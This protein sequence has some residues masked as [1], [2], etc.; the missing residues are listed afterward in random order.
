MINSNK[1]GVSPNKGIMN[2]DGKVEDEDEE[3]PPGVSDEEID[4][5]VTGNNKDEDSDS[6][7]E[8]EESIGITLPCRPDDKT[9]EEHNRTHF[10][11]RNWCE[12]CVRGRC[13][14]DPHRKSEEHDKNAVPIISIDYCYMN[15]EKGNKTKPIA[16]WHPSQSSD[17]PCSLTSF[18]NIL[19]LLCLVGLSTPTGN[20]GASLTS[21][22]F[23]IIIIFD[24]TSVVS[25]PG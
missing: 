21:L 9:V 15:E 3:L 24:F 18:L 8:A 23:L 7:G 19:N 5:E 14:E 12:V 20:S 4:N 10:P 6:G 2:V 16:A 22:S 13:K 11:C 1:V 25:S 17:G